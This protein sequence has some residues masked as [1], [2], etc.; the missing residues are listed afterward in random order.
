MAI[1]QIGDAVADEFEQLKCSGI[2]ERI[3]YLTTKVDELLFI[4]EK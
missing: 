3:K 1:V 2:S 4:Q